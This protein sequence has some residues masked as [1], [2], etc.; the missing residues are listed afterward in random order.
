MNSKSL[1]LVVLPLLLAVAAPCHVLADGILSNPP[2]IGDLAT[3]S[4]YDALGEAALVKG[5][6]AA[7]MSEFNSA[8]RASPTDEGYVLGLARCDVASGD[9]AEADVMY[10]NVIGRNTRSPHYCVDIMT[11]YILVLQKTGRWR[12][13]IPYYNSSLAYSKNEVGITNMDTY[14]NDFLPD[15][16]D[17]DA[18]EMTAVVHVM[19]ALNEGGH[20]AQRIL[21]ERQAAIDAAPGSPIVKHYD[22]ILLEMAKEASKNQGLNRSLVGRGAATPS[23]P[24]NPPAN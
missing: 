20:D 17:Y 10:K 8:M 11:E 1:I 9:Y 22:V 12:D 18:H 6:V 3:A 5:D 21:S 24:V 4:R 16:S 19:R 23:G 15:G 2:I 14:P 13:A 7:A